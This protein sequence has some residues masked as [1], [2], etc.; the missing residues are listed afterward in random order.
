LKKRKGRLPDFA[1][2]AMLTFADPVG[3]PGL[4]LL[5]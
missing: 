1:E 2:A 3:Q 4:R 5:E